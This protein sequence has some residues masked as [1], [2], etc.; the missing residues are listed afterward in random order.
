LAYGVSWREEAIEELAHQF[1]K[2][3]ARGIVTK[4]K[5]SPR[6]SPVA[7]RPGRWSLFVGLRSQANARHLK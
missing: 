3:D 2:H 5:K 4:I 6:L 1:L 7:Y